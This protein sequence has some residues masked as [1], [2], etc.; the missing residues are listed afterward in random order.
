MG[1]LH[2][3]TRKHKKVVEKPIG[4]IRALQAELTKLKAV[5]RRT[6]EECDILKMPP[7]TLPKCLS[8][9]CGYQRA[10]Q[11]VQNEQHVPSSKGAPQRLLRLAQGVS[12]TPGS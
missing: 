10:S 11:R 8:E 3:W 1:R 4:D 5:L 9:V 6:T 12:V 2:T 7:R